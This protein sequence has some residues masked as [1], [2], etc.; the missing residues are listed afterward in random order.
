LIII[1]FHVVKGRNKKTMTYTLPALP[2]DYQALEP[3][4]DTTTMQLH[5]DKH[6]ATYVSKLNDALK[7]MSGTLSPDLQ[8]DIVAVQRRALD[9]PAVVR[10]NGGG[11]YNHALFWQWMAPPGQAN[12]RPGP[13]L[14]AAID[15]AFGSQA[16]MQQ[17]FNE[18][19]AARFG[20]GWAWLCVNAAT[21]KD[22]KEQ[23]TIMSTPNQD[24]PLM[25]ADQRLI[26]ILGLDVWEHAYYLKYQNRRPEY[27]AKWWDV[28]NWDF[29]T[30]C[31]D[32]YASRGQP[33]PLP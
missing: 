20:S 8:T 10:N 29:V 32:D 30:T 9:L 1:P 23:M 24:N 2:Y 13:A 16:A 11:H 25:L 26:P 12:Q 6:H 7:S 31:Y 5:H 21:P 28:V 19:A 17:Q 33:V 27:I 18:A 4:I 15:S 3:V 14:L 22:D